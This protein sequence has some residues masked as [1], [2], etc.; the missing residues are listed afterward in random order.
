[1][2]QTPLLDAYLAQ[3]P[4]GLDSHPTALHKG[5]VVRVFLDGT[6]M[7]AHAAKLPAALQ[8]IIAHPPAASAWVPEVHAH[9]L[10]VAAADLVY[11]SET[12]WISASYKGN[13][14]LMEGPLY[15]V[16]FKVVGVKRLCSV[17][18]SRWEQLHRGTA[19]RLAEFRGTSARFEPTAP[20]GLLTELL[21][22]TYATAVQ[23]SLDLAGAKDVTT[24]VGSTPT[25][26][27]FEASWKS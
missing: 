24:A 8:G 16:L 20:P 7:A 10:Y 2:S 11:R 3:L 12:E 9:A 14:R 18:A 25:G 15:A 1:M 5:S 26:V 19:L 27:F 21:T 23:A 17:A 22:R 6:P 4:Q 13:R